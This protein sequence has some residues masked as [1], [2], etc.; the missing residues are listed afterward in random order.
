[1]K[2]QQK[3][4]WCNTGNWKGL[5]QCALVPFGLTQNTNS[6]QTWKYKEQPDYVLKNTC[7]QLTQLTLFSL[8]M[9]IKTKYSS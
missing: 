9:T 2:I 5:F 7:K 4:L 3:N 6:S 8:G 1:M